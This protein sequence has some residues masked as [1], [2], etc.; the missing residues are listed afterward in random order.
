MALHAVE[1]TLL[2]PV[3]ASFDVATA[4]VPTSLPYLPGAML[5]GVLANA[6][7]RS[8]DSK[9]AILSRLHGGGLMIGDAW[10]MTGADVAL[11]MPKSLHRPKNG[12]AWED[13]TTGTRKPDY[14]Q[15]KEGQV[16][17]SAGLPDL[18]SVS[19][20][21][22]TTRRTAINPKTLMAA[23]GQFYGLQ[24]L[25][26]G[27]RF[28][29]L[30][31]GP[32]AAEAVQALAGDRMLGKSRNAEFGRVHIRETAV[33]TLPDTGQGSATWLWCLSD[34]AAHH[35]RFL[36]TER[37]DSLFGADID[38]AH[39]FVR[40][41]SYSPYNAEWRRRQP[42]RLVIA[43][44]SVLM[45]K[46]GVTPGMKRAGF[47]QE[48]GLGMV[49]ACCGSPLAALKAW[50][51]GTVQPEA[52]P[53]PQ[54]PDLV[55]W[56]KARAALAD[57]RTQERRRAQQAE[58]EWMQH[59]RAAERIQGGRCGPTPSQWG[60]IA[61]KNA[62]ALRDFLTK[63]LG[64]QSAKEKLAWQAVFA[65]G[66]DGTFAGRVLALLN[67]DGAQTV[68]RTAKVLRDMLKRERWFDGR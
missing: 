60:A 39:S 36:P 47:W 34:L 40:H 51:A 48:Q 62:D 8:G 66:Q 59:Y 32:G 53:V 4:A 23:D 5:W 6:A 43:R 22:M 9:D 64:D 15:A 37:P 65:P 42:E 52:A 20:A 7:Y 3:I 63:A 21:M 24:A 46:T 45:L 26:A 38:W 25:A 10:P 68:Q 1:I 44:G 35:E 12:G 67:S 61:D 58:A 31:D 50:N 56:L 33:P 27:Q 41:R 13:W 55:V 57:G 16:G 54:E 19:V 14:R 30:I 17:P 28:L 18:A 11:P 2:D 29:A 49:L